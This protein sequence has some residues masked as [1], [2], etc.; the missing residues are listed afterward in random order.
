MESDIMITFRVDSLW[1]LT[2]I[3]KTS[4]LSI[5]NHFGKKKTINRVN[6]FNP[7]KV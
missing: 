3:R 2:Q 6:G 5:D 4:S 7:L 1:Y